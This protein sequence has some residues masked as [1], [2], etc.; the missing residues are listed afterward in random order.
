MQIELT[1]DEINTI[2]V[3]LYNS[4]I[5]HSKL[6][7]QCEYESAEYDHHKKE[8]YNT[9]VLLQQFSDILRNNP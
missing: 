4:Q 3:G 5:T 2:M 6:Q 9:V 1:R 8:I 7:K